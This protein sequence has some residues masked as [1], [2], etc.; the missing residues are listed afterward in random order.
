MEPKISTEGFTWK[1]KTRRIL[2][3]PSVNGSHLKYPDYALLFPRNLKS[4]VNQ[5]LPAPGFSKDS[6]KI[7]ASD[8][9]DLLSFTRNWVSSYPGELG[10]S[11]LL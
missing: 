11:L 10:K 4:F 7:R 9:T 1:R 6:K 3:V 5:F 8:L 2:S